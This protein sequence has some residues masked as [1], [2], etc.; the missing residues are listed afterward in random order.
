MR[1]RDITTDLL[2]RATDSG[3]FEV[4]AALAN[5]LPVIV[6]AEMLGVSA[7]DHAQF[8]QWSNDLISSFGQE[9]ATGPSAAGLAAQAGLRRY[10]AQAIKHRNANPADDLINAL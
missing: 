10:R 4:M 7:D 1:V 2:S 6:I 5:P 9:M 3:E 8:K